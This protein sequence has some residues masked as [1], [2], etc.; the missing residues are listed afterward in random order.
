MNENSNCCPHKKGIRI[1][2]TVG[3]LS[4]QE[5]EAIFTTIPA[6]LTFVDKDDYIVYYN[7]PQTPIFPRKPQII[8]TTIQACH[9]EASLPALNKII[10]LLRSGEKDTIDTWR[11]VKGRLI[12]IKYMAARDKAGNYAGMLEVTT[13]ITDLKMI[14][15]ERSYSEDR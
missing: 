7:E 10:E 13:D 9:S 3:S 6:E 14:E 11:T 1:P 5:L 12:Y 8:G 15:G 2:L 4:P